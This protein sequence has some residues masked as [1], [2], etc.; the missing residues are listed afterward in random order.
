M[1]IARVISL[2]KTKRVKLETHLPIFV[3][4]QNC[5]YDD[6]TLSYITLFIR[7]FYK[8]SFTFLSP[9]LFTTLFRSLEFY[10]RPSTSLSLIV[11]LLS[12]AGFSLVHR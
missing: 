9:L 11:I 7:G 4:Q 10:S 5:R 12:L 8:F 6:I 1:I 2:R 3:F